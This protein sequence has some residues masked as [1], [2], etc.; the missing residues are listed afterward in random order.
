[1]FNIMYGMSSAPLNYFTRTTQR[2]TAIIERL[3]PEVNA[4]IISLMEVTA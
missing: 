2:Y 4:D 3:L 1:M